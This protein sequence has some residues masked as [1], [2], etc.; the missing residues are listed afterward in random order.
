MILMNKSFVLFFLL[1]ISFSSIGQGIEFVHVTWQEALEEAKKEKKLLFVDSYAQ[2]CGPCKRMAKNEFVKP[3]VGEVFN[4]NFVNL[5]LDMETKNGRTFDS[6]YPVSAYPTMFFLSGDGKVVKKVKGGKKGEQLIALAKEAIKSYDTSE[7]F[8][9]KYDDGDRS[10]ETVYNYVEALN[11][12][13]KP[14]LKIS[15]D[16]LKSKPELT[17]EQEGRFLHTATLDADSKIFEKMIAKKDYI[18]E[19]VGVKKYNDKVKAAC[20]NTMRK[21][22][23]YETESLL[24]EAIEKANNGLTKGQE[25]FTQTI[26]YEYAKAMNDSEKFESSAKNLG[27]IYLK[28]DPSKI[29]SLV[30]TIHEKFSDNEKI[31]NLSERIA[32]KYFKQEKNVQSTMVY[33]KTLIQLEKL[34]KA[35]QVLTKG[36]KCATKAGEKTKSLEMLKKMLDKKRA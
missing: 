29:K 24:D 12:A 8:K 6:Q 5:K 23:E 20:T 26:I 32:K 28:T 3:E 11:K 14:S 36:L 4:S 31:M 34:D 1:F 30:L 15:N 9:V 13:G 10:Y 19:L 17:K 22:V 27:K 2:W 18:S 35:D 21:A 16:Y 25:E 7:E 33:V